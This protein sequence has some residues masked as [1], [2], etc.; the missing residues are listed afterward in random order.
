MFWFWSLWGIH[1]LRYLWSYGGFLKWGY[2]KS[3]FKCISWKIPHG[4]LVVPFRKAPYIILVYSGWLWLWFDIVA[5]GLFTSQTHMIRIYACRT[6]SGCI[7]NHIWNGIIER[8]NSHI[9]L[10]PGNVSS[11]LVWPPKQF[12]QSKKHDGTGLDQF[13]IIILSADFNGNQF[14]FDWFSF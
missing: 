9:V 11:W 5:R 2:P 1:K 13:R 10:I 14:T 7:R 8:K 3:W 12:R 4:W 6:F